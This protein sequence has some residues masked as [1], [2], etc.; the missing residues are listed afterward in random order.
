MSKILTKKSSVQGKI[1]LLADLEYGE[2]AINLRDEIIYAKT[3]NGTTDS[4]TAFRSSNYPA[5]TASKLATAR[6]INGV[7]FDGTSDITIAAGGDDPFKPNN[8]AYALATTT[9]T[10]MGISIPAG[11]GI[12]VTSIHVTNISAANAAITVE[13]NNISFAENVVINSGSSVDILKNPKLILSG[14]NI[15]IKSSTANSLQ[16]IVT[17]KNITDTSKYTGGGTDITNIDTPYTVISS[18]GSNR[19]IRSILVANDTGLAT[20]EAAKVRVYVENS[21]GT[22]LY[23]LVYDY[24]IPAG[25]SVEILENPKVLKANNKVVVREM[26]GNRVEVTYLLEN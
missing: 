4:I 23:Y 16:V 7:P 17:Y 14:Q 6:N 26:S 1:P 9:L 10:S 8:E 20:P 22:I 3:N 13:S 25:S 21:V 5:A 19:V 2:L 15:S 11:Q 18:I 12:L 24:V